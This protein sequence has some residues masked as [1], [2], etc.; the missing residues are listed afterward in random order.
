MDCKNCPSLSLWRII[1]G[2]IHHDELVIMRCA[3]RLRMFK[4]IVKNGSIRERY[5]DQIQPEFNKRPYSE[6]VP[7]VLLLK[8]DQ[9]KMT[10]VCLED[11][12]KK[13]S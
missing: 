6:P 12:I 11:F 7:P 4:I 10:Y 5:W 13:F 3:T 1:N 2:L 8:S 9:M